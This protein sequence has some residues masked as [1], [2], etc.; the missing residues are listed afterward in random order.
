MPR[1]SV[2]IV[3]RRLKRPF[4]ISTGARTEQAGLEVSLTDQGV[5]GVGEAS[6]VSYLGET[7]DS[8]ANQ[9]EAVRPALEAGVTRGLEEA[10]PLSV[11]Q[12]DQGQPDG[13]ELQRGGRRRDRPRA[14]RRA[15]RPDGGERRRDADGRV[16]AEA[17][18][19]LEERGMPLDL[20]FLA[21]IER[22]RSIATS[23]RSGG[24]ASSASAHPSPRTTW[25]TPRS[26]SSSRTPPAAR[27]CRA[28]SPTSRS[29]SG[30]SCP[31]SPPVLRTGP[32][33]PSR[34]VR[35]EARQ[36]SPQ[37]AV[38][39]AVL[40]HRLVLTPDAKVENVRKA[41]VLTD[42]LESVPVPTV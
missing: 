35:L 32:A 36:E 40:A 11:G 31:P 18:E 29:C 38:E 20:V 19:R 4:V 6:G 2:R 33:P 5:T 34:E 1:L 14:V 17:L 42:V 3:N 30:A 27:A 21:M 22:L 41:A 28:A 13:P 26:G 8:L 37:V 39:R 12:W 7:A 25:C 16:L 24:R 9:V 23:V 15:A 10:C